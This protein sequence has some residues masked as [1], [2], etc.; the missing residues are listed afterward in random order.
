MKGKIL[1]I[2]STEAT[3]AFIDGTTMNIAISKLP[4]NS[5]T[6]DKINIEPFQSKMTSKSFVNISTPPIC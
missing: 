5:K 3:I 1:F 2:D 6:G 4:C